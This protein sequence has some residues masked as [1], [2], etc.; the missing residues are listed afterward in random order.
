MSIFEECAM[1]TGNPK[2][3][4]VGAVLHSPRLYDALV[5]LASRG[6]ERR[7]RRRF[8]ELSRLRSGE[9][10]LDVGCGTGTLA[11]LAGKIVGPSGRVCGIDASP[12]MIARAR[13]KAVRAGIEARFEIAAAQSLPFADSSFDVALGTLMLHHL[14][15]AGRRELIAE[16]RRVLRP[17]GRALIVDFT[18]P[19]AKRRGWGGHF[20]HRRR[21]GHVEATEVI[22]LLEGASFQR[23]ESGVVCGTDMHFVL[24]RSAVATRA[25]G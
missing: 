18:E 8:L 3:E 17:G 15:R 19:S 24:A 14:G 20:R 11:A 13:A 23:L 10:V 16:L 7:W 21:H 25:T 5:W 22:G 6:R 1:E 4:V 12:Q 2:R 9:S